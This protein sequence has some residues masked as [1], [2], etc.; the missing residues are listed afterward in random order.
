MRLRKRSL[1]GNLQCTRTAH[2]VERAHLPPPYP[3]EVDRAKSVSYRQNLMELVKPGVPRARVVQFVPAGD[4]L[5]QNNLPSRDS[6][7]TR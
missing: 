5:L 3:T 4:K 6:F 7:A 2:P 1:A